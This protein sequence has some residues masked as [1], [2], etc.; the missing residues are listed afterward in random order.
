[1]SAYSRC[2]RWMF[3]AILGIIITAAPAA[4]QVEPA[5]SR[6]D[7]PNW[8]LLDAIGYGGLGFAIAMPLVWDSNCLG[9][10]GGDLVAIVAL[11]GG[12]I[13]A[14]AA[15]GG[16]ARKAL[17][18]GQ[19]LTPGHRVA[20]AAGGVLAGGTLGALA[21]IPL[22]QSE[23]EGTAFGS[24]ERTVS[25]FVLGGA[26]LGA[27]FVSIKW[28]GLRQNDISLRPAIFRGARIGLN[29]RVGS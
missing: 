24:D 2:R 22:I 9:P 19:Q 1:M 13:V 3:F 27:L 29:V 20:V 6:S 12:G 5:G 11:A 15:I 17:S 10:C 26:A 28:D 16:R 4:A 23:G 21:S 14:G 18:Q 7:I 8:G 25:L